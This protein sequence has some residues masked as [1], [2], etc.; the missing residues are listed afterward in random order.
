MKQSILNL[1]SLLLVAVALVG[2]DVHEW[3]EPHATV[4]PLSLSYE[5][6]FYVWEHNYDPVLGSVEEADPTLD[7]F[8]GYP[9]TS[10]KY[11]NVLSTGVLRIHV[12]AFPAS[13]PSRCVVEQTFVR[14][15][16]GSS[17]DTNL[18]LEVPE[19]DET[20]NI[21]IWSDLLEYPEA[22]PFYTTTDFSRVRIIPENYTG[23]TDYRDGY[24]GKVRV[25]VATLTNDRQVVSMRRPM[26]KF[27]LVTTDLSEFL[28]HETKLQGQL[29]TPDDYRVV[30]SFP[31]YYPS[32]YSAIDD[33][34]ENSSTGVSFET[35]MTV[36]G[37]SEASLGFEYVML[38]DIADGGV[39]VR[40]DVYR[41]KDGSHVA[42][43]A[44]FTIPMRRDHHT[45]L[46]GAFF[47]IEGDGGIGI[48][49][50]FNGDH[51]IFW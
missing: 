13:D 45:L 23:N 49:P 43:S 47:S 6:D 22:E 38:N 17:Y 48:D 36:T 9:G 1:A 44:M 46:R 35:T 41:L 5:T 29:V 32:S 20:Y 26:G 21:V 37:T 15:I 39:Q 3:P 51:N 12:K 16:S 19:A 28:D 7:I 11:N 40:V 34:L 33:F 25:D 24:R 2:C 10:S 27:E 18:D 31:M 4:I 50:G 14:E 8:P 30:I 42:G